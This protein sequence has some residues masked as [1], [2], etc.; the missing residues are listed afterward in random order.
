[1]KANH[2]VLICILVSLS[3]FMNMNDGKYFVGGRAR[4]KFKHRKLGQRIGRGKVL[5]KLRDFIPND[6][7]MNE[8]ERANN[9]HFR[10]REGKLKYKT[11]QFFHGLPVWGTAV[12]IEEDDNAQKVPM[13]GKYY[14]TKHIE[15]FISNTKPLIDED[16]AL[17]IAYL[18][19]NETQID[20]TEINLYI[21]YYK[22]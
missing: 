22:N 17:Q 11:K 8:F 12:V 21:Y 5:D 16:M 9:R 13:G 4:D 3:I 1:M 15:Q 2:A 10:T 20:Y 18:S 14:P 19:S 7:N 6:F